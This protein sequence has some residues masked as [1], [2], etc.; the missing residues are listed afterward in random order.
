MVLGALGTFVINWLVFSALYALVA[1]GFTIIF[2][3]GGVLNLAHGASLTIGAFVTFLGVQAGLG[4]Y[5]SLLAAVVVA[6]LFN[7]FLY[8]VMVRG[9]ERAY[10]RAEIV[11]LM[12]MIMTLLAALIVEQ[13]FRFIIGSNPR[14]VPAFVGGTLPG[15]RVQMNLVL[16]FAVSWVVIGAIFYWVNNTDTGRAL[17]AASISRRGASLVGIDIK[18]LYLLTWVLAGVLAAVAGVFLGSFENAVYYMGRDPLV[19]S[20]AVVVLGGL[21]SI[22]GSV[23]GAYVIGFLEIATTTFLSPRATGMSAFVV[24]VLVLLVKPEGLYGREL[25]VGE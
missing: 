6:G 8:R 15:T 9:L 25:Q 20:F 14:S 10:D 12:V 21:G 3:V 17:V 7:A 16:A 23:I 13:S 1:I 5:A 24:L 18:R 4:L 19:I 2:G 11:A 22:R